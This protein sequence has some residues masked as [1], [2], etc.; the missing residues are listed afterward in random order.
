MTA[1]NTNQET[2][3]RPPLPNN[4]VIMTNPDD[5]SSRNDDEASLTSS[6]H[7]SNPPPPPPPRRITI[8]TDVPVPGI[9]V[10]SPPN[11]NNTG[12]Y[13]TTLNDI[14]LDS[15]R[16]SIFNTA[17]FA[18]PGGGGGG[19]LGN[20]NINNSNSFSGSTS[21]DM[22]TTG[23]GG[24]DE[25]IS[26]DYYNNNNASGDLLFEA[27]Q[28]QARKD[29]INSNFGRR[30]IDNIP[31]FISPKFGGGGGGGGATTP[32][33]TP[34]GLGSAHLS[35]TP[36]AVG[37]GGGGGGI[38]IAVGPQQPDNIDVSSVASSSS[39]PLPPQM[40]TPGTPRLSPQ[41]GPIPPPPPIPSPSPMGARGSRFHS[42]NRPVEEKPLL[43]EIREVLAQSY[44][45]FLL[46]DL[47]L[48][49]GTGRIGTKYEN[50]AV[51]SDFYRRAT[52]TDIACLYDENKCD[53]KPNDG[54]G[55]PKGLSPAV[56][57]AMLILEIRDTFV[58]T[59]GEKMED[60]A[61]KKKKK[62]NDRKKYYYGNRNLEEVD[63]DT[64]E[65]FV[66]YRNDDVKKNMVEESM[67]SL[68]R[69]YSRMISEDLVTDIP[70]V[71][72][73]RR[74]T[75]NVSN[76]GA[77]INFNQHGSQRDLGDRQSDT[78][79]LSGGS[80][81]GGGRHQSL[82]S[83]SRKSSAS[84]VP[85][86]GM[87]R[88]SSAGPGTPGTA[89]GY[90]TPSSGTSVGRYF[91]K[92]PPPPPPPPPPPSIPSLAVTP[93]ALTSLKR[94][95]SETTNNKSSQSQ[96]QQ[97]RDTTK[98]R[99]S[100]Q[101][102]TGSIRTLGSVLEETDSELGIGFD[103]TQR[104]RM[105][106]TTDNNNNSNAEG[107]AATPSG[108]N[109]TSAI[110]SSTNRNSSKD[111]SRKG[112][113]F[114]SSLYDSDDREMVEG[115]TSTPSKQLFFSKDHNSGSISNT[116]DRLTPLTSSR[117][118]QHRY[119]QFKQN[120]P[121][122]K[123]NTKQMADRLKTR[124]D[125]A[126]KELNDQVENML[127]TNREAAAAKEFE[128]L[129][130]VFFD[131]GETNEDIKKNLGAGYTRKEM[132]DVMRHAVETRNDGRLQFLSKLFKVGS[133][134][135]L[136]VQSHARVV[137]MNDWYPLKDLTY[138][139]SVDTLQ[140]RVMV[141]FRG[142]ITANDWKNASNFKFQ[143]IK[144]PVKDPFDGRKDTLRV[145]SGLYTY[146]FRKRKDTGTTKYEEIANMVHKYGLERIGPDYKLFVTGHSLGGA[147]TH[148][149]SFFASTEERFTKNGPVK[150]IAFA[151]PYIGGHSWADS[152]RHQ[153][154][155]KKLQIVQVRNHSD[156]IPRMPANFRI[157]KRGPL[158]RH[159]GIGVTLP[160][161]PRC[162]RWKPLVHYWGKEKSCLDSTIHGFRRNILF[163]FSYF[164]PWTLNTSHT[165]F[166]LQD[167]LM[168]GE[169][170]SE[171]GGDFELLQSTIDELYDILKEHNFESFRKTKWW[172]SKK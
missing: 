45:V 69:A 166:E 76:F 169:L 46:A 29:N 36:I 63:I 118:G 98:A 2:P 136:L 102:R 43:D 167:R 77:N 11:N 84:T 22:D 30:M 40:T 83:P 126:I 115:A 88:R 131:Q 155:S 151:S 107:G 113:S 149:F 50:L 111:S 8:D 158:W 168:Y 13:T 96:Q 27:T 90:I 170:N 16:C 122:N 132:V 48:M 148:F 34:I 44:L 92:T 42:I 103:Q 56:I 23:T 79:S 162:G 78:Q 144:N 32:S 137:W 31:G 95:T 161:L 150:A 94:H 105:T 18:T 116:S 142:A 24:T 129:T 93:L 55:Y 82:S 99:Q 74:A 20:N 62:K 124:R 59:R 133:V 71:E 6:N 152:F 172:G 143:K 159:V 147:L 5:N 35:T 91:Q 65:D 141:V 127:P 21:D 47:R 64:E 38:K 37:G 4:I 58:K 101:P 67:E 106:S 51:D 123:E 33:A 117:L 156:V 49:S 75:M 109:R 104:S 41:Y 7:T 57:M 73:R 12:S 125:V 53:N 81:V 146:L 28:A 134:S 1:N 14:V 26:A 110:S 140:R 60:Q 87:E 164:R 121:L 70:N 154:R 138:A 135:H 97:Q 145:F 17:D 108:D 86:S 128:E 54:I 112:V 130:D 15:E 39:L 120:N 9:N 100:S 89:S 10:V 19:S 3:H 52:A 68:M 171:A 85:F 66:S 25:D 160:G 72:R 157:G 163:H 61:A 165:L 153:E 80:A 114:H 119:S 139:I